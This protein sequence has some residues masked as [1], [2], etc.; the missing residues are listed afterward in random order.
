MIEPVGLGGQNHPNIISFS[1][2]FDEIFVHT[3]QMILSN[4]KKRAKLLFFLLESSETHFDLVNSK[5]QQFSHFIT[6]F[7]G[8]TKPGTSASCGH[9][10]TVVQTLQIRGLET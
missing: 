7:P 2:K 4:I 10:R 5:I 9:L 3:F 8:I 6:I 1:S